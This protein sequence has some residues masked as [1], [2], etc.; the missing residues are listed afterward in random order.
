MNTR[1]QPAYPAYRARVAQRIHTYV[2]GIGELCIT[3]TVFCSYVTGIVL[4]LT[5][6][7]KYTFRTSHAHLREISTVA[8]L[9]VV[10]CDW[11]L[12]WVAMGVVDIRKKSNTFYN[13]VTSGIV[14]P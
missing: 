8:S 13:G 7:M 2:A 11:R 14:P 9:R 3:F 10:G 1:Q 6:G 4:A 5:L 12:S